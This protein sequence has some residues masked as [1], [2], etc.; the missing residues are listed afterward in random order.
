MKEKKA[1]VHFSLDIEALAQVRSIEELKKEKGI[2]YLL[3]KLQSKGYT[4][5]TSTERSADYFPLGIL[6]GGTGNNHSKD[7]Q[8][9]AHFIGLYFYKTSLTFTESS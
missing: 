3:E 9:I 5:H 4:C 7:M 1:I 6:V 2:E 8:E